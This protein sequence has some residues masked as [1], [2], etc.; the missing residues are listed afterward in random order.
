[1]QSLLILKMERAVSIIRESFSSKRKVLVFSIFNRMSDLLKMA[2]DTFKEVYW[3]EING[4]TEQEDRQ[5]II[6][7]FSDYDGNA[8]L[9]LNP[10]AAGAGLN[11]TAATVVIH[12]TPNWNPALEAQAS[13]RAHRRGQK[14]P[15]SI[16]RLFY[17]D[18]VEDVM[19]GR[20][21]WKNAMGNEI[22]PTGIR[23]KN[24]LQRMLEYGPGETDDLKI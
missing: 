19:I 13:A 20:S 7:E 6:D 4:N 21:D 24:D 11:I 1:M 14:F 17:R 15:V 9:V 22:T 10:K 8:L 12:M 16:Y 2:D 5:K 23:D 18:T 3:G